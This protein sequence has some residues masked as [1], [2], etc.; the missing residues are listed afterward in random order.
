MTVGKKIGGGFSIILLLTLVLGYLAIADMQE[1]VQTSKQISEDRIPR[2][3]V[4]SALES[5]VLEY[6]HL[7]FIFENSK[8]DADIKSLERHTETVKGN[9]AKLQALQNKNPYKNTGAFL[10]NFPTSPGM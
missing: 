1:G 6:A 10:Q 8:N 3:L 5:N 9:I 4:T 7:Y 2:F